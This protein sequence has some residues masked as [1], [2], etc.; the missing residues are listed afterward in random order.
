M[1]QGFLIEKGDWT[2]P[3]FDPKDTSGR[4]AEA[5]LLRKGVG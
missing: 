2:V 5:A 4:M 1:K 3:Y